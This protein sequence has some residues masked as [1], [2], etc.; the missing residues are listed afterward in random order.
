MKSKEEV[1]TR[2]ACIGTVPLAR[3]VNV[4]MYILMKTVIFICSGRHE[5]IANVET[6]RD[7]QGQKRT[8]RDIQGQKKDR[9]GHT[10]TE[11][12]RQGHTGTDKGKEGQASKDRDKKGQSGTERECP[13][14]SLPCL[15]V[16]A[17][18]CLS[19]DCPWHRLT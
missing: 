4:T 9:Q 14:L 2:F 5:G 6:Y 1:K 16:P 10:G 8:D 11:K 12:G 15:L 19:L 17:C 18:P 7:T 3:K 13:C